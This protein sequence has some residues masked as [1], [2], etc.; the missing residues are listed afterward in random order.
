[1]AENSK[2]PRIRFKGFTEEWEQRKLNEVSSYEASNLTAQDNNLN[3]HYDLYD[4]NELIGKTDKSYIKKDYISIIKDGAGVGRIRKLPQNT[5]ILGTMGAIK[6]ENCNYKFLYTLLEKADLGHSFSGSTIPHIYFKDYGENSYL[7]PDKKEQ[8]QIGKL[9]D[10]LDSLIALHQRKYDKLSN[11]K[12]ALLE[13]MFPKNGENIPKI[14]F[15][16]FTEAWEQR[17][18]G[19]IANTTIGEFVIKTKQNPSSPY[20]VYN[21][22]ISY[23]GFYDD[24]NNE[25][26]KIIISARGANAGFVNVVKSRYWAG[27]SCY[28]VD[29]NNKLEFDLDFIYQEMK[30]NQNRF[31]EN[32]QAANIPSVSKT[33]VEKFELV[34]PSYTEQVKIGYFFN[35]LD[36]LIA[37]HQR[38]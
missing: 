37:L 25:G 6:P 35:N 38:E 33:D 10:N 19:N 31:I 28:S 27:N 14:R 13:K 22:G 11:V 4:A 7:I 2:K 17:K 24:F 20:P 1:M 26:N 34:T 18:V 16:G 8:E 12:K 29:I 5:A 36:S 15:K 23:T 30:R 3:G 9:F 32:Q 21:G